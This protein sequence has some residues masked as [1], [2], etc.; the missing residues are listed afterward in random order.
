MSKYVKNCYLKS[1]SVEDN[2]GTV[3]PSF[4]SE[5]PQNKRWYNKNIL[6]DDIVNSPP[7]STLTYIKEI[8][9]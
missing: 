1:K 7:V 2:S 5:S 9:N 6:D 3:T 8:E 4:S